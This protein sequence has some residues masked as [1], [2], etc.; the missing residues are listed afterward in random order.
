MRKKD[1]LEYAVV[2][3]SEVIIRRSA[4]YTGVYDDVEGLRI[5]GCVIELG[6]PLRLHPADRLSLWRLNQGSVQIE[7]RIRPVLRWYF[8]YRPL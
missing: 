2:Y 7:R 6:D 3:V 4:F 8:V 1:K 5:M